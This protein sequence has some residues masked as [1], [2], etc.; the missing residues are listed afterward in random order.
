MCIL[1]FPM[2]LATV[3]CAGNSPSHVDL[4]FCKYELYMPSM[5]ILRL[6]FRAGSVTMFLLLFSQSVSSNSARSEQSEHV[7]QVKVA[8]RSALRQEPLRQAWNQLWG[9]RSLG[10]KK[11]SPRL[12]ARD[13]MEQEPYEFRSLAIGTKG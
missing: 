11:S 5:R 9:P 4:T 8:C 10:Q 12:A 7:R 1:P 2:R 13:G 3:R 6:G